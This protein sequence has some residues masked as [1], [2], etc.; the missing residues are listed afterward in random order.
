MYNGAMTN[1]IRGIDRPPNAPEDWRGSL[2]DCI[3]HAEQAMKFENRNNEIP[4]TANHA[5]KH[6]PA[7]LEQLRVL[8]KFFGKS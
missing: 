2:L 3:M 6:T 7:Q 4:M 5:R 8:R 1:P